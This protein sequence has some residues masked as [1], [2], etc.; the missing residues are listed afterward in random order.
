MVIDSQFKNEQL[1]KI[2]SKIEDGQTILSAYV[3]DILNASLQKRMDSFAEQGL[4]FNK[5][6]ERLTKWLVRLT[7]AL[8]ILV[9]IQAGILVYQLI[10]T[11][12]P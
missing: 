11:P 1:L 10:Q 3:H 9:V 7:W 4:T 5:S 2:V 6:V 12:K 8:F